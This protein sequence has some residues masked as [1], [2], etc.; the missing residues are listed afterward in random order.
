MMPRSI[1]QWVASSNPEVKKEMSPNSYLSR[2]LKRVAA[3][4]GSKEKTARHILGF[5]LPCRIVRMRIS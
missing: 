1:L 3:S 2:P 5:K 4:P